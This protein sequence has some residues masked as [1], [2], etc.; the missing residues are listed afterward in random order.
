MMPIG[1]AWNQGRLTGF[2]MGREG[3]EGK[4]GE[5]EG[6]GREGGEGEGEGLGVSDCGSSLVQEAIRPSHSKDGVEK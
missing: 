5:G 6:G 1:L 2:G 4:G 3:G